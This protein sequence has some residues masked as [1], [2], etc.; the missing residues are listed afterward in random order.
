MS[1]I[2]EV[3]IEAS[4]QTFREMHALLPPDPSLGSIIDAAMAVDASVNFPT[5]RSASPVHRTLDFPDDTSDTSQYTADMSLSSTNDCGKLKDL[6][7][8]SSAQD[9]RPQA[10]SFSQPISGL[11]PDSSA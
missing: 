2:H 9:A 5:A 6:L 7:L 3:R 11:D 4:V 8:A 1:P 10:A